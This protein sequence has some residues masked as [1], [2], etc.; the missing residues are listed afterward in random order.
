MSVRLL[1]QP[2]QPAVLEHAP[3]GL[4]VRAVGD[5]VVLEVDRLQR[6][7]AARARLALVAVDAAA[8]SAACRGSAARPP[9]RSA[10]SRRR[11]SATIASRSRRSSSSSQIRAALVRRQPRLPQDLID[12]RAPD[13]R[14]HVLVAQ[15]RVQRPRRVEQ[16]Q[17]SGRGGSGH[18]SGPSFA[19]AS[20]LLELR[21]RAAASPRR[22]AWSR[23]RA[24]AARARPPAAR[25]AARCDRAGRRACRTAAAARRTSGGSAAPAPPRRR[26]TIRCLPRRRTA[27]DRLALER[28]R[29][30]DRTSSAR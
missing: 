9:A 18:A 4:A 10:R 27:R 6:R 15:Q 13:A 21:R 28:R 26:S 2:R 12:P 3:L 20:S 8:A 5:H 19:S 29:A 7:G 16:L 24:G 22:P 17:P 14:D 11:A 25:A 1:Q 30:A 23:T